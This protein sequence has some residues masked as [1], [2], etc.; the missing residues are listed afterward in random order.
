[1]ILIRHIVVVSLMGLLLSGC[2][3]YSF[4]PGGKSSI[5]SIA[6][7][8]FENQTIESGLSSAMTDLVVQSFIADGNLSVVSENDA[9]AILVGVLKGYERKAYTFDEADNVS[10]YVVKLVFDLTLENG[11]DRSEIWK[12]SFY[13]EGVYSAE[14]ETEDDGKERAAEKLV[15]D[16]L[17]RTTKDW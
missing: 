15:V 16:I 2:A 1:M 11:G 17:N 7:T 4:N 12:E 14:D 10:Q 3:V 9:D 6:V 8:Q 13:S 5:K